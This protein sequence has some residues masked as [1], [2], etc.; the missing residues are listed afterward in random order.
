MNTF[1]VIQIIDSLEAGGAE[2]LAV[3]IAN[4]FA[5]QNI[6]SYLCATRKEGPLKENLKNEVR[7]LFLE[8]KHTFDIN[9]IINLNNYI[10]KE[11]IGLIHAHS[12]SAFIA[13]CMKFLNPRIKIIWH[14]HFG[15]RPFVTQRKII[16]LKAFSFFFSAIIVVNDKLK[17]WA[18]NNLYCKSIFFK[19]INEPK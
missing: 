6:K 19:M 8:R 10:K 5:K 9:A 2:M 13:V 3:N 4:G 12:T 15:D 11:N 14:D 18:L 7:Y 1:N 17:N 16:S